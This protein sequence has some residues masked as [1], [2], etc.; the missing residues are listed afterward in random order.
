M[1]LSESASCAGTQ[2]SGSVGSSSTSSA[3]P[4]PRKNEAPQKI[5]DKFWKSFNSK[6]PGKVVNVL[7]RSQHKPPPPATSVVHGQQ[8]VKSYEEA[9]R[10]CK[11]AVKRIEKECMRSN[12]KYT[13]P[14][15]DI[16]VDLKSGRRDCLDGLEETDDDMRPKGVKRVTDIFEK[17]QFYVNNATASDVRQGRDGDCWLMAALS[18]LTNKPNLIDRICVARNE[19]VGVYGFVF[20][21]DGEWR[22]TIIDDKLY[23]SA[24]DYDD[25]VNEREMWD[26][27][28][29]PDTEDKYRK[30]WQTGSRALY[31]A[32]CSDENE[33]WL[34]LLEKAYAK[35]HGDYTSIAGGFVGEAIED[36]TGGVTS[37]IMSTNILD[38]ERFWK[39]DLMNVNKEFLFGCATG[40]YSQ[41]LYPGYYEFP[42]ERSGIHEAHAYSIMDAKEIN[43]ERLL[44]LRNPWGRKEWNGP[45]SDGSEQWTPQ[46]ME[47]LDHK[48]GNDGM[49]WIS[50]KDFLNKFEHFDRTR[51]FGR[52]WTV[53]QKW[54]S[55]QV[56]WA[57]EYHSTKFFI[58]VTKTSPV[59]IVLSQLDER[60]FRG[61]TGQYHF[62]LQFRIEQ[63]GEEDYI[64]RNHNNSYMSRSV[65]A[66]ITLEP[67]KYTV[68]MKITATKVGNPTIE[69]VVQ[70]KANGRRE[71]LVQI[72]RSYDLA[73][74]KALDQESEEERQERKKREAEER[75][76]KRAEYKQR[77]RITAEAQQR[78][79]WA[80]EKKLRARAKRTAAKAALV[81][82]KREA[83]AAANQ[84]NAPTETKSDDGNESDT[85]S[86]YDFEFDSELDM[87]EFSSDDEDDTDAASDDEDEDEDDNEDLDSEPWNAVCVVGLRVYSQDPELSL[88]VVKPS[89][90]K[91][92]DESESDCDS[93]DH[94][95]EDE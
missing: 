23:L 26:E 40:M 7:P 59:V 14:Y 3:T 53:T 83:K 6:H 16:E 65:S 47:L 70:A 79:Q 54:T 50:Y 90:G 87:P 56:P 60:Y 75:A 39:E 37:E 27:I 22:H 82:A 72:G 24:P 4:L 92:G 95:V 1:E 76:E 52:E 30:T 11:H 31:F 9:K 55:L 21:R 28:G 73:H 61:L 12:Q 66:D 74:A 89:E 57:V 13:D 80:K 71:K 64:I 81:R 68:L 15:F 42:R 67:G 41:W 85:D 29:R 63:E 33:T 17:P 94:T 93:D 69:D 91:K 19:A 88:R 43:G 84:E 35:A 20:H 25:A 36:L 44:R 2:Q 46:W 10:E 48:F 34:P 32:H 86:F 18:T 8:A 51:L 58:E 77:V 62:A 45:W 78:K 5:I 38:K 49:F